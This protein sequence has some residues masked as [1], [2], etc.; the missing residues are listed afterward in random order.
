MIEKSNKNR[1]LAFSLALILV[2]GAFGPVQPAFASTSIA[3]DGPSAALA[4]K[5]A[6]TLLA[7]RDTERHWGAAA[8]DRWNAAQVLTGYEDGSFRP[9]NPITRGEFA[10]II[11]RIMNYQSTAGNVFA[12]LDNAFYTDAI[13]KANAA[14]II[15]GDGNSVRPRDPITREEAT[16]ILARAFG[17]SGGGGASFNDSASISSWAADAVST[18]S[19]KGYVQGSNGSFRPKASI[20]R[21][22]VATILDNAISSLC[23]SAGTYSGG[24]NITIV[25]TPGVTIKSGTIGGGLIITEG[26]GSGEVTLEQ[27]SVS[28]GTS[29]FGGGKLNIIGG[30]AGN[31]SI[32]KASG[33]FS[34]EASSDGTA[35]TVNVVK[36][37]PISLKGRFG[38]VS[39]DASS[40]LKLSG[41]NVTSVNIGAAG[42]SL[43]ADRDTNISTVTIGGNAKNVTLDNAGTIGT[44]NIESGATGAKINNTGRIT[45]TNDRASGKAPESAAGGSSSGGGGSG[46]VAV[47]KVDIESISVKD[48]DKI[49]VTLKE[50]AV[51]G[52]VASDV[53]VE[54]ALS[55]QAITTH[56]VTKVEGS[57]K[58]YT[59]SLGKKIPAGA[60]VTV[61]AISNS[62]ALRGSASATYD[63]VSAGTIDE[64]NKLLADD[65]ITTV[66]VTGAVEITKGS[67]TIKSGKT[68]NVTTG[69]TL[70]IAT[71]TSIIGGGIIKVENKGTIVNGKDDKMLS[72]FAPGSKGSLIFEKGAEF[73]GLTK[74]LVGGSTADMT[75][76]SGSIKVN[77]DAIFFAGSA[78]VN[79]DLSLGS[80]SSSIYMMDNG[81]KAAE[82]VVSKPAVFTVSN[83]AVYGNGQI[84]VNSGATFKNESDTVDGAKIWNGGPASSL[85]I[86]VAAGGNAVIGM[87]SKP[88]TIGDNKNAL[89][90][91]VMDDANTGAS[92][93][94]KKDS[95][96]FTGQSLLKE[97]L[98]VD[99]DMSFGDGAKF[100]LD[101]GKTLTVT[102]HVALGGKSEIV[103]GSTGTGSA[104]ALEPGAQIG[105]QGTVTVAGKGILHNKTGNAGNDMWAD[106]VASVT[107]KHGGQIKTHLNAGDV[108]FVGSTGGVVNLTDAS[109]SIKATK[110]SMSIFGKV[111]LADDLKLS[112]EA[113]VEK[114]AILAIKDD[115]TIAPSGG[116]AIV[117]GGKVTV[118][119]GKTITISN[120]GKL[121]LEGTLVG[122]AEGAKLVIETGAQLSGSN[123]DKLSAGQ[124]YEW[125]SGAWTQ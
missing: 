47:R 73:K 14:G 13:L 97:N 99:R 44:L 6:A 70:T 105:G 27:T 48:A 42:S 49:A 5:E 91:I 104:L 118:D 108:T 115:L 107:V 110:T 38:T 26:A 123:P 39:L 52:F 112:E 87:G 11:G 20:T 90:H 36:G 98:A 21:A 67:L 51:R 54:S 85:S 43:S 68:V 56:A 71:G 121:V 120:N 9:D 80:T 114:D 72:V 28:G 10:V 33:G 50:N 55:G 102:K 32:N 65:T 100:D 69:A 116:L 24:P 25:N 57:A 93:T 63:T 64:L 58:N 92:I 1:A 2:V 78:V 74:T 16:V 41:A 94:V 79:K 30:N 95:I 61:S 88:L 76:S 84:T 125:K 37:S 77:S 12:D 4:A 113:Q 53:K 31:V 22:E 86:K 122:A 35:S 89:A 81:G 101:G 46:A 29:V 62:S 59:M 60:R 17:M 18:L 45:T 117:S 15:N 23:S 82:I 109:A 3:L 119:A 106:G 75:V 19:A 124:R 34:I 83:T 111:E 40:A 7:F 66:N 103:V 96:A 8:V